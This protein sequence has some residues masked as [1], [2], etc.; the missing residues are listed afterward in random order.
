MTLTKKHATGWRPDKVIG[1][2]FSK[3]DASSIRW[4]AVD[5]RMV[6]KFA[7][8][9]FVDSAENI[10]SLARFVLTKG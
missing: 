7:L 5:V 3:D 6:G 1:P 2:K 4:K 10:L 8:P 9:S